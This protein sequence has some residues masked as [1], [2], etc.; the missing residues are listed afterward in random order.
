MTVDVMSSA[1]PEVD[2]A[3]LLL[4][5]LGLTPDDLM[6]GAASQAPVPTFAQ[7]VPKVAAAVTA[8]TLKAYG[9]Y[10]NRVVQ[11]W[12]ARRLDEPSP[13]EI[14]Q[15]GK[16]IRAER[17]QRRNGRGGSGAEEN[18]VAAMRCLYRRA[19]ANGLIAEAQNPAARVAKPRRQASLRQALR[20]DRLAEINRVAASGGDDPQLDSLILRLH[21]ETACRRG[22]A[23]G[24]RPVDL[25]REQS[26]VRL[27]E[28][29]GTQRWQPVSPTL[30]AHLADHS[31]QRLASQDVPLLRYRDGR[32]ITYRRY[33]GLWVRLGRELPWVAAQGTSTH[34][35]RHTIL[36]WVERNFGYAVARAYAGHNDSS[37][38]AGTTTTY[39]RATIHEVA[40]A[41][42]ALT[43]EPHPLA[44]VEQ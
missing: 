9:S 5:R 20:D 43:G 36:T 32:P 35:I 29:G 17:V 42:A 12:G 19:V 13:L 44:A 23:L 31:T 15:L 30:M 40:A 24:L 1:R 6:A 22:G 2:A 41:L 34:W 18:F 14:E 27:R 7:F 8:G 28:K 3:L 37:H 16:Q 25:D 33:D 39:V 21:E 10:W 4:A 26:L 38:N 11:R